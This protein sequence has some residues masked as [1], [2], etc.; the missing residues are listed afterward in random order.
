MILTVAASIAMPN[1]WLF[2]SEGFGQGLLYQL[3]GPGQIEFR[4]VFA[5]AYDSLSHSASLSGAIA[6][7]IVGSLGA[8][9]LILV[10]AAWIRYRDP[11]VITGTGILLTLLITPYA[12]QYDYAPLIVLVFWLL[13][14]SSSAQRPVQL[15]VLLLLVFVFSV[16]IWQ[17]WSYQGYWQVIGVLLATIVVVANE[18]RAKNLSQPVSL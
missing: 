13:M 16:L 6:Y 7:L 5:T 9:G 8:T 1:W 10:C 17:E 11:V 3:Q 15:A 14:R 4:R 12:L 2:E 18:F